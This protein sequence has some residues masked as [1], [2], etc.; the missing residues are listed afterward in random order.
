MPTKLHSERAPLFASL[1]V[2]C[3]ILPQCLACRTYSRTICYLSKRLGKYLNMLPP[4][5]IPMLLSILYSQQEDRLKGEG[6][7]LLVT[8]VEK[9]SL[10][11]VFHY[12]LKYLRKYIL[13]CEAFEVHRD[14]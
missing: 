14:L 6:T 5:L 13:H 4:L 10:I 1:I 12:M 11:I 9:S 8:T 2:L 7:L 3:S